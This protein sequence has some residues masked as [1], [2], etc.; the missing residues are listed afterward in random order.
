M[1]TDPAMNGFLGQSRKM[2]VS[3]ERKR[4]FDGE[5]FNEGVERL[6]YLYQHGSN[7]HGG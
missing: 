2:R 4:G 5:K 3:M 6:Q 7:D 1:M